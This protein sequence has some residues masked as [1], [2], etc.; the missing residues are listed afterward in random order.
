MNESSSLSFI[1]PHSCHALNERIKKRLNEILC[2]FKNDL[3]YYDDI[4]N[5]ISSLNQDSSGIKE[6]TD[7]IWGLLNKNNKETGVTKQELVNFFLDIFASAKP[8][9]SSSLESF[10]QDQKTNQSFLKENQRLA[11]KQKFLFKFPGLFTRKSSASLQPKFSFAPQLSSRTSKLAYL[12]REKAVCYK[13]QQDKIQYLKFP[14]NNEKRNDISLEYI[15][16][17]YQIAS[18]LYIYSLIIIY[19]KLAKKQ[20]VINDNIKKD[21]GINLG[22]LKA[23]P[24]KSQ[25]NSRKSSPRLHECSRNFRNEVIINVKSFF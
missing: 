14:K 10:S 2:F 8:C 4:L 16:K 12:S 17:C 6:L 9:R 1:S 3:L 23:M 15:Q 7:E 13:T 24:C 22:K 21:G 11:L 25:A 5:I 20:E 19:R 18:Q